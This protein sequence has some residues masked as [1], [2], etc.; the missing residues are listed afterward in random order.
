MSET[1][2]DTHSTLQCSCRN[3]TILTSGG[4]GLASGFG[5]QLLAG[6]LAAG[7][8]ASR[9]LGASHGACKKHNSK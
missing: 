1:S 4:C 9:L 6:R 3:D 5:G 2:S 8:L 7:G